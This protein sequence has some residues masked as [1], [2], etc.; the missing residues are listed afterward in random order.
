MNIKQETQRSMMCILGLTATALTVL[1]CYLIYHL[2]AL[3][4]AGRVYALAAADADTRHYRAGA[5]SIRITKDGDQTAILWYD[6]VFG[7]DTYYITQEDSITNVYNAF[8]KRILSGV[9]KQQRL[10]LPNGEE[11]SLYAL[12]RQD[13]RKASTDRF[14]SPSAADALDIYFGYETA[15]RGGGRTLPGVF[16]VLLLVGIG[17]GSLDYGFICGPHDRYTRVLLENYKKEEKNQE[18]HAVSRK[19]LALVWAG[20]AACIVIFLYDILHV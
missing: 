3:R 6:P 16:C 17:L 18:Y 12:W 20:F 5:R 10:W 1:I 4:Y 11:H 9:W 14:S 7:E 2:P 15:I 13:P 8:G 19:I